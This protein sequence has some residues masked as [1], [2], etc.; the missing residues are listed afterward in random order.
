MPT[1]KGFN[2]IDQYKKF[3]LTDIDLVKRDLL[4][5]LTIRSGEMPGRPE[6]GSQIWDYIFDPNDEFTT[7]KIKSEII[8]IIDKD[9]RIELHN[10]EVVSDNNTIT[11]EIS[12]SIDPAQNIETF[13]IRFLEDQQTATII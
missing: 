1:F 8:R 7:E 12:I 6:V 5:A 13:Y 10:L 4:N 11:A 2:T 3:T 9:I